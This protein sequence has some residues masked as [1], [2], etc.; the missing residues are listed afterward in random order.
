ML[1]HTNKTTRLILVSFIGSFHD[2]RQSPQIL[3]YGRTPRVISVVLLPE[4]GMGP[5][6][7]AGSEKSTDHLYCNPRTSN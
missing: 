3:L 7:M 4:G 1:R 5:T 2:F 6:E